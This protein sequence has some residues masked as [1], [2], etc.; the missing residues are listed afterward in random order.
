MSS[1]W[2]PAAWRPTGHVRARVS[3]RSAGGPAEDWRIV[4]GTVS[5]AGGASYTMDSGRIIC[6][7]FSGCCICWRMITAEGPA[8]DRQKGR[9]KDRQKVRRQ[10]SAAGLRNVKKNLAKQ[11][12]RVDNLM[13]TCYHVYSK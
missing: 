3:G 11:K 8:E 9:Q 10:V 12:K 13:I 4:C 6:G 7:T 1:P 2:G 5:A